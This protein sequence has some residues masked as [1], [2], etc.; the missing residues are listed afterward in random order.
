MSV[1]G[2]RNTAADSPVGEDRFRR[3][4]KSMKALLLAAV[5]VSA[6]LSGVAVAQ[7]EKP[8]PKDS[9]RVYV[10]GCSKGLIFTAGPRT[11]DQPGRTNV[12]EGTHFRMNGPKKLMTEI[13]AH[14]G[15][16]IE[17]TG[18][19]RKTPNLEQG[20]RVAPGVRVSPGASGASASFGHDPNVSQTVIDVESWRLAAAGRCAFA[21][22]I[23]R[24]ASR[25][26]G[27]GHCE[28]VCSLLWL[29]SRHMNAVIERTRPAGP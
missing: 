8:V 22:E 17:L 15:A 2:V 7:D 19:I 24:P 5:V 11:E 21:L 10:P 20:V 26:S 25:A 16:V 1:P 27:V 18:L 29:R 6:A 4:L 12:P 23:F 9:V 3:I 13:K 28:S 14:E